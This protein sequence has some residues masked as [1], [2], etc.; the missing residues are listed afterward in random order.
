MSLKSTGL[1]AHLAVTGSLLDALNNGFL[2]FYSGPVPA[3]ADDILDAS[4]AILVTLTK[5]GDGTTGLTFASTA[6]GGALVKTDGE[7][8]K[9]TIAATGTATFWRF[10]EASDDGAS[11]SS[12]AKRLQGSIGTT[13]DAEIVLTT[14]SLVKD[15]DQSL[16]LFQVS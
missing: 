14:T 4:S 3:A 1:S 9:G 2:A 5:N 12:T 7:V 16:S 10:Y 11:N 6:T 8:W 15:Q 13:A